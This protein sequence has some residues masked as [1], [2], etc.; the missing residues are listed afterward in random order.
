MFRKSI[1]YLVIFS[2]DLS[3]GDLGSGSIEYDDRIGADF[4]NTA[5]CYSTESSDKF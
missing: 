2:D 4:P 5:L 3:E 1:Y